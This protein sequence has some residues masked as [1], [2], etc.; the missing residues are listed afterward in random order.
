MRLAPSRKLFTMI[1]VMVRISFTGEIF[2]LQGGTQNVVSYTSH[3]GWVALSANK[4]RLAI[5]TEAGCVS[6]FQCFNLERPKY[7]QVSHHVLTLLPAS[8]TKKDLGIHRSQFWGRVQYFVQ[9]IFP[10]YSIK[11]SL[12]ATDTSGA[13]PSS[14]RVLPHTG[15][16]YQD[17]AQKKMKSR[18]PS[19]LVLVNRIAVREMPKT[20]IS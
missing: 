20:L 9:A 3:G 10:F 11:H 19:R 14:I 2:S 1:S 18:E 5:V 4:S 7:D 12:D 17:I 6:M 13:W 15:T 8:I 16:F